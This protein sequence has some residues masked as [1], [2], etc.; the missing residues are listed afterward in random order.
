MRTSAIKTLTQ[1]TGNAATAATFWQ[2]FVDN[3]CGGIEP[4]EA[5]FASLDKS[6]ALAALSP[7]H[8]AVLSCLW[9]DTPTA[10]KGRKF[11]AENPRKY[12][13]AE[14]VSF[15]AA[16]PKQDGLRAEYMRR[17]GGEPAL[18]YV[19]GKL[20]EAESADRIQRLFD[21]DPVAPFV[22]IGGR[23][24]KPSGYPDDAPKEDN[25][26]PYDP[27]TRLG[28]PGDVSA[29]L[30]VSLAGID[31]ETRQAIRC[32]VT[33]DLADAST[34]ELQAD[35][36]AAKGC[37]A[38]EYLA[39]KPKAR[40]EWPTWKKSP[41]VMPR[42]AA[43]G[44]FADPPATMPA[45]RDGDVDVARP[46]GWIPT[47]CFIGARVDRDAWEKLKKH[48]AVAVRGGVFKV[49]SDDDV[50]PGMSVTSTIAANVA[51]SD[52]VF[53]LVTP[54]T[55]N[56]DMTIQ[57][58]QTY[59]GPKVPLILGSISTWNRILP[60]LH[61][62]PAD[63][64]PARGDDALSDMAENIMSFAET[65]RPRARQSTRPTWTS[66]TLRAVH[67]AMV[68]ARVD[69]GTLLA[70]LPADLVSSLPQAT[71]VSAQLMRDM[72]TLKDVH[73]SDG[74]TPLREYIANAA[75]HCRGQREEVVFREAMAALDA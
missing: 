24:V 27:G 37:S 20:C 1:K 42:K 23:E 57:L 35:A 52:A 70:G 16:D 73:M 67:A 64:K 75:H 7:L 41:L 69:R 63:G 74:S 34:R 39:N 51:R 43:P 19:D 22:T 15:I 68:S 11:K 59:P 62:I 10:P 5:M 72:T 21:R 58:T 33:L 56:D 66:E 45:Q 48:L 55:M 26:D 61:P 2:A 44:P 25:E 9:P 13:A 29:R 47:L 38:I 71:T 6:E 28:Q 40:R 36:A 32:A 49:I 30:G 31:H 4:N 46:S 50:P 53:C 8:R 54:L 65:L 12:T 60:R 17:T 18:F 14:I 3:A